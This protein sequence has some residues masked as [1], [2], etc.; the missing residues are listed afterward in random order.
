MGTE[1]KIIVDLDDLGKLVHDGTDI[2][3]DPKAEQALIDLI[4]LQAR[5]EGALATVKRQIEEK[6]LEYNPN[7]TS[8]QAS[9]IK[10]GYQFFGSKYTIDESKIDKL[11][12]HM[13]KTKI[14]YSPIGAE[15]D[16]FAKEHNALPLGIVERDR[17]KSITIKPVKDFAEAEE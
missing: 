2:V 15:V 13:Y 1:N 5:V 11:P 17:T 8:V 6:A 10:V 14:T 16:K 7:F 9:R 12:Q 4:E 3:L